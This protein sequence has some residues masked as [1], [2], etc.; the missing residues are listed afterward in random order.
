MAELKQL[1]EVVSNQY[2]NIG[3]HIGDMQEVTLNKDQ[4]EEFVIKA[5]AAREPHVFVKKDGTIDMARATTIIKPNQIIEPIRGEDKA[6]NLWTT[7]NIIQERLVK[8][9]F[10]RQTMNGRRTKPRGI[11]NAAR[12][13]DF[14]IKLWQLAEEYMPKTEEVTA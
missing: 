7:F 3:K 8:G 14:N 11:N 10:N 9:E 4:R 2:T 13:I 5:I 1:M 12:H 6:E